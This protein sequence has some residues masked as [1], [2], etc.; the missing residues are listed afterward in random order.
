MRFGIRTKGHKY[1]KVFYP[2]PIQPLT[3]TTNNNNNENNNLKSKMVI[4]VTGLVSRYCA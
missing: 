3:T 4:S 2:P 1:C